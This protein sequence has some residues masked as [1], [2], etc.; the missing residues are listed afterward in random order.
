MLAPCSSSKCH[1]L[2]YLQ[3][4][5]AAD[6]SRDLT[7][8][9]RLDPADAVRNPRVAEPAAAAVDP[10]A[11]APAAPNGPLQQ[12]LVESNATAKVD[13]QGLTDAQRQQVDALANRDREVRQHEQAHALVGGPYAGSPSYTYQQGPDGERYAIG[14]EVPIDVAPIAGDPEA[15]LAK[16]EVVRAAAL[17]PAEPSSADHRIAQLASAQA[18][19]AHA[20]L[21]SANQSALLGETAVRGFAAI[22]AP[23]P[24]AD[25]GNL[26]DLAA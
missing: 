14:G 8:K 24:E 1:S 12:A 2:A 9:A 13:P 10:V 4:R 21:Q 19:E 6:P 26:F 20:Q 22:V 25:A 5:E 15:T 3:Q 16:M 18:A 11:A 23:S 7:A 17:A